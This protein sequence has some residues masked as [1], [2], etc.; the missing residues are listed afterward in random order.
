MD[1]KK[2]TTLSDFISKVETPI[3]QKFNI[4][5]V[6]KISNP[7]SWFSQTSYEKDPERLYEIEYSYFQKYGGDEELQTKRYSLKHLFEDNASSWYSESELELVKSEHQ[8]IQ[9]IEG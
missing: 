6:V 5:D 7:K 1:H 2:Y 4:G 9:K 3:G 8:G